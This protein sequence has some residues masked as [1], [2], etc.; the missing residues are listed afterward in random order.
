MVSVG[1]FGLSIGSGTA[2]PSTVLSLISAQ[3]GHFEAPAEEEA[4]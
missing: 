1:Y 2:F 4:A 3:P